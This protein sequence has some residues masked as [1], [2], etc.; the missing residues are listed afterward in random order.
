[1]KLEK[2]YLRIVKKILISLIY[3]LG[4][5]FGTLLIPIPVKRRYG[6]ILMLSEGVGGLTGLFNMLYF[7]YK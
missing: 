6:G 7:E 4:G 2:Q 3:I 1:L 5:I